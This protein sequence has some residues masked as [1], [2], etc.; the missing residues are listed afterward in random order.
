MKIVAIPGTN[1][2]PSTNR[3]LLEF[4][5]KHFRQEADIELVE[6][7]DFPLFNKPRS[8]EL[9]DV[10]VEVAEKIQAADAVIIS[11]PEYNHSFPSVL[12]SALAWLSYGIYPFVDK[13]VLVVGASYGRLGSSR[14]QAHLHQALNA[15]EIQARQ[16]PANEFLLGNSY[17]AFDEEGQLKDS[18]KV[19]ELENVFHNFMAFVAQSSQLKPASTKVID[20]EDKFRF[21]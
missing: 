8:L 20:N 2:H 13:P 12:T 3:Q 1:S 21:E 14:A 11:T 9:P 7:K 19:K 17:A 15:E 5:A 4:M 18:Q 10:V 6:I 16:M